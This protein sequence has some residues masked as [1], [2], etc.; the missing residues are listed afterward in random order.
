MEYEGKKLIR[1]R[2][3]ITLISRGEGVFECSRLIKGV[4]LFSGQRLH[5]SY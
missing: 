2:S 1:G 5:M 3:H 4:R